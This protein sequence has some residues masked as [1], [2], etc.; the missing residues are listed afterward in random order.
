MSNPTPP[1]SA[2]LPTLYSDSGLAI[3]R[4][5]LTVSSGIM[6]SRGWLS[7][8]DVTQFIDVGVGA[9][10]LL[11]TVGWSV[12]QKHTSKKVLMS[13][14]AEAEI[15]EKVAGQRASAGI[16]TPSVLTPPTVVPAPVEPK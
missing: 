2:P 15:T 11:A 3:V 7:Q 1:P 16:D 13:A 9:A 5:L 8:D 4:H 6:L 10:T 12:W 14:L